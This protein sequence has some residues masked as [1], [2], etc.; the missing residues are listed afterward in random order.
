MT[1]KIL[2]VADDAGQRRVVRGILEPLGTIL[3]AST[4]KDALRLVAAEK[5]ELM[6]LDVVMTE[7]DVPSIVRAARFLDPV[8]LI[9]ML[10]G[11]HVIETAK[12]ALYDG[13]NAY[14]KKP[15]DPE[16]LR[17][18]VRRLFIKEEKCRN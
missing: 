1:K 16:G 15:F 2:I 17:D 13:T 11:E 10:T 9:V 5:P 18:E 6:L 7:M 4:G 12:R 8:L 14:I 3:E